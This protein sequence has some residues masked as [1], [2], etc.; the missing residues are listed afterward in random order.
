MMLFLL[1]FVLLR[2]KTG[3]CVSILTILLYIIIMHGFLDN[4]LYRQQLYHVGIYYV[5][6]GVR[7]YI[8]ICD[9]EEHLEYV[10][11]QMKYLSSHIFVCI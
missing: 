1:L 4:E 2:K 8:C 5:F 10:A 11:L 6:T 7:V 9:N 3:D